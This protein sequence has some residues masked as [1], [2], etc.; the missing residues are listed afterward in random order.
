MQPQNI[1]MWTSHSHLHFV[2]IL[3]WCLLFSPCGCQQKQWRCVVWPCYYVI[4]AWPWSSRGPGPGSLHCNNHCFLNQVSA[5]VWP[6]ALM[7][8]LPSH[9]LLSPSASVL[10][11]LLCW[12]LCR[13]VNDNK[14]SQSFMTWRRHLFSFSQTSAFKIENILRHFD[15]W[16]C[17]LC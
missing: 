3:Y 15:K 2:S 4:P 5:V 9:L 17:K 7:V 6:T 10:W 11:Y 1:R 16:A 14:H 12:V 13:A 8:V